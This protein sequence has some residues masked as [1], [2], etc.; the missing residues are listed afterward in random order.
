MPKEDRMAASKRNLS[1]LQVN[2]AGA[3]GKECPKVFE[4]TSPVQIRCPECAYIATTIR[5]AK[6]REMRK[7]NK[8]YKL[9]NKKRGSLSEKARNVDGY[10]ISSARVV[11]LM[12]KI[13]L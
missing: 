7:N 5:Q 6:Y 3:G 12:Q 11:A 13:A 10:F 2:C 8:N 1:R 4:P 9:V